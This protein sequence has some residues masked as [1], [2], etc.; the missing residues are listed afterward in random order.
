MKSGEV[1]ELSFALLIQLHS[2]LHKWKPFPNT[3]AIPAN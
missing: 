2:S 1:L 3:G